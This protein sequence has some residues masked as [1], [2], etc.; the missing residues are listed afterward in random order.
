[1]PYAH[2]RGLIAATHTPT[3]AEGQVNLD[4]IDA[5]AC[6]LA[7]NGC[8]G[9]FVCGTTGESTSLTVDER[10]AVADRWVAAAAEDLAVIVNVGHAC[11]ADAKT[12]AAA[13]QRSG[14]DGIGAMGPFFIRPPSVEDLVEFCRQIAAAAAD[15][16]FYYYHIPSL[17]SVDFRM[18]DF[19]TV[20]AETIPNL[21]GIKYTHHNLYDFAQCLAFDGGRHDIL[22]GRDE[23]LL[24]SLALGATGAVGSTYNLA[25]PLYRRIIDAFTSGDLATAR[26]CQLKS[27]E[28]VEVLSRHGSSLLASAKAAMSRVGIDC[29]PVRSPLSQLTDQEVHALFADLDAMGFDEFRSR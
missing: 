2:L 20:A 19:L 21:A 15:L 13:A 23:I 28:L 16:P 17:T 9:A 11:L 22:F 6:S 12:L 8:R 7:S 26:K 5:Q 27:I 3:D 14:A 24:A 29:G 18:I 25:A 1:M 10:R 4:V